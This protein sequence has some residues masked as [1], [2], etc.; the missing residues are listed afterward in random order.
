MKS[1]EKSAEVSENSIRWELGSSWMQHLQKKD[2]ST[3]NESSQNDSEGVAEE[4]SVKGLGKQFEPLK[5]IKK[6]DSVGQ[7]PSVETLDEKS[8]TSEPN[9][10]VELQKIL[11]EE[12]FSR[13]KDSGTGLH[14]KVLRFSFFSLEVS[15]F[16]TYS[17]N[18]IFLF[19][20]GTHS[21]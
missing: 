20:I 13:L 17:H 6:K 8:R 10:E 15:S 3:N 12:A 5:K 16:F 1:L 2:T 19:L 7:N 21:H 18:L 14:S 11:P 4:I 9:E